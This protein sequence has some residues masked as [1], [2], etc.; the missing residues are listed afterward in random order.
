MVVRFSGRKLVGIVIDSDKPSTVPAEKLRSIERVL[1]DRPS[2]DR[3]LMQMCMWLSA[4]YMHPIGEVFATALPNRL[5]R[6]D[7]V[8]NYGNP[9][10]EITEEGREQLTS[11][12]GSRQRALLEALVESPLE[13]QQIMARKLAPSAT[14]GVLEERGWIAHANPRKYARDAGYALTSEQSN[15]VGRVRLDAGFRAHLLFGVTG[16]GKTEVYLSIA[17]RL[18]SE[19]FQCLLLVPEIGLTPQLIDRVRSR[20]GPAVAALH[21]HMTDVQ[22][23]TVWNRARR[24]ELRVVVGTRS[25][26]FT[27]MPNL[28]LVVV[29]EEHDQSFKQADGLRYSARD[30]AIKRA[31]MQDV[32]V[33]LGSATPSL[34]SYANSCRG[35][36]ELHRMRTRATGAVMPA[37]QTIDLRPL[38][39]DTV[40]APQ[41]VDKMRSELEQHR[42]VMVFMNRRGYA[43][44]LL[45]RSCAWISE[46]PRCDARTTVHKHLHKLQCHHCGWTQRNPDQCPSCGSSDLVALGF[47]TEKLEECVRECF[48]DE[49]IE[50]LDRDVVTSAERLDNALARIRRGE[51]RIIL[52][53]QMLAKGHDFPKVSLVVIANMDQ[54]LFSADF[55]A[56]ERSAQLMTQVAGRAGR[57][58]VPGQVLVQTHQPRH[59]LLLKVFDQDYQSLADTLLRER[60]ATGF[61][62]A[63]F[64]VV[65]RAEG[66]SA[67]EAE[68]FLRRASA[69]LENNEA[70]IHGPLPAIMERVADRYRWQLIVQ[71]SNRSSLRQL[72]RIIVHRME[73]IRGFSRVRWSVDVDPQEPV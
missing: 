64:M 49:A 57:S 1:T 31:Q 2:V 20:M 15:V 28:G 19:R 50:R 45:C 39:P 41:T 10:W 8:K 44:V 58:Q 27:P 32:P 52:G 36:F 63:T 73:S 6:I 68:T 12:I 7:A 37:I 71:S 47:G 72:A 3:P 38:P 59:P 55:R 34:E 24:G 4:Y 61:P 11:S 17:E 35:N 56:A 42:Q 21:S 43:P 22:R 46:C 69:S 70:H 60:E 23:L 51:A 13:S 40:L 66:R 65:V 33:I 14:V 18:V 53:T 29:D 48:P 5:M 16:S 30:A 9:L 25:A 67:R 54:S 26:L 62:P